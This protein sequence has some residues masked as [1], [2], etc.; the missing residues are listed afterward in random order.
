[1]SISALHGSVAETS[2]ACWK[3]KKKTR[4]GQQQESATIVKKTKIIVNVKTLRSK[5]S[6]WAIDQLPG[7]SCSEEENDLA[8]K[9]V[10]GSCSMSSFFYSVDKV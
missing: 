3:Q 1:M 4:Y 5:N 10:K 7:L 2:S 6:E 8:I 9:I